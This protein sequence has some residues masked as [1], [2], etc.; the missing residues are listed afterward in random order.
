MRKPWMKRVH[1]YPMR[2]LSE[3]RA[4]AFYEK[5]K[6]QN[7]LA[8]RIGLKLLRAAFFALIVS[9]LIQITMAVAL[10]M[11]EQGWLSPPKLEPHRITSE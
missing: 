6:W 5:Y 8:R 1:L 4:R 9:M 3:P 7:R 11:N 2:W 10:N